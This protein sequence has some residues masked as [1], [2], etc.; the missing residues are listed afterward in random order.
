MEVGS[1]K[2]EEWGLELGGGDIKLRPGKEVCIQE[3]ND[4]DERNEGGGGNESNR[5]VEWWSVGVRRQDKIRTERRG[6][7]QEVRRP[8]AMRAWSIK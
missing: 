8:D 3:M 4:V 7:L 5:S 2:V 1:N 6:R